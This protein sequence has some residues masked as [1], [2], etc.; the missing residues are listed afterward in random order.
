V[1]TDENDTPLQG[2]T[3]TAEELRSSTTTDENGEYEL[4]MEA[5]TYTFTFSLGGYIGVTESNVEILADE[6]TPLD[7]V[8]NSI[9]GSKCE[10]PYIIDA[11]PL[12]DY[13]DNTE[14]YGDFYSSTWVTPSTSYLNGNDFVA[15]FTLAEASYLTGSVDGSWTGLIIVQ[16]CPDSEVPATRLAL[17]SGSTGGSFTDVIL[18]PGTYFAIV[19]TYPTP[20]FTA[21][22]LNLSAEPVLYGF[23]AGTV[24]DTIRLRAFL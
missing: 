23:L 24:T 13:E 2:V 18:E 11:L 7:A 17:A 21:F 5:G 4:A 3:I 6:V 1:V 14:I 15:Q 20:Q 10:N 19:S 9:V 22:T 16:D 8:L 12:V